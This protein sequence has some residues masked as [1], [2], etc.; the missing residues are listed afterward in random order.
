MAY[1][2]EAPPSDDLERQYPVSDGRPPVE[3]FGLIFREWPEQFQR[4]LC[5]QMD[6]GDRDLQ[7]NNVLPRYQIQPPQE[8]RRISEG[9]AELGG[10]ASKKLNMGGNI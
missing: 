7:L 4:S 6:T 1:S 9:S 5:A 3:A 8:K 10:G 2:Q